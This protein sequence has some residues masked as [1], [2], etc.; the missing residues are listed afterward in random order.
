MRIVA[1]VGSDGHLRETRMI[2]FWDSPVTLP[3]PEATFHTAV[4][5]TPTIRQGFSYDAV[6][7]ISN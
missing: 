4:S 7:M 1:N 2:C 5:T 3:R 6:T